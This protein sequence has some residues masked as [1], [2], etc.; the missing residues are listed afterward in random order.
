MSEELYHYGIKGMKW[1]KLKAGTSE[2]TI[3]AN[4]KIYEVG[5]KEVSKAAYNKHLAETSTEAKL[6]ALRTAIGQD[7]RKLTGQQTVA[8]KVTE[9][10]SN[11]KKA[12]DK[13]VSSVKKKAKNTN[14]DSISK[15]TTDTIESVKKKLAKAKKKYIG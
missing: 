11:P 9:A 15:S 1:K 2:T 14:V 12:V 4:T 6:K 3:G 10:A 7:Y 13:A 5:G 8:D